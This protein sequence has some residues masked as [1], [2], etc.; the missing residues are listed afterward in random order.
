MKTLS[1]YTKEA[2]T[3]I[4]NSLGAFFAFSDNQFDMNKEEGIEYCSLGGGLIVPKEKANE[5][6]KGL[7][8]ISK[9]GKEQ[10]LAENGIKAIIRRELFNYESF[11]IGD[12]SD[13]VEALA[14]YGIEREDIQRE[15]SNI[16]ANEDVGL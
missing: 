7:V 14:S 10:D 13:C 11:Y 1:D 12:I 15:Y 5:L 8:S 6:S 4:F 16:L 3:D 9:K 2:H